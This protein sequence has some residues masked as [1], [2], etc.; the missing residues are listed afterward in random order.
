MSYFGVYKFLKQYAMKL[1][2]F[3]QRFKLLLILAIVL[4]I[5]QN[6]VSQTVIRYDLI[7]AWTST[8]TT[9]ASLN[10]GTFSTNA[11]SPA[12]DGST[13]AYATGWNSSG[14][15]W[16]SSVLSTV[17]Y[18]NVNISFYMK[19]DSNGPKSFDLQYKTSAG[20]SWIQV[21][22]FSSIL[23]TSG[24]VAKTATLPAGASNQ[25]T[26]YIQWIQSGAVATSSSGKNYIS[27]VNISAAALSYPVVQ[28]SAIKII[29]RTSKTITVSWTKGGV[30][31]QLLMINNTNDFT[32]LPVNNE[33][34]TAISGQYS[35]SGR[36]VIFNTTDVN[37]VSTFTVQVPSATDTYWF[38]V[39][40]YEYNAG[41]TRYGPSEY[42][43]AVD[44]APTNPVKCY[45]EQ[46]TLN[47]AYF[48]LVTADIG[49][50][51]APKRGTISERGILYSTKQNFIDTDPEAVQLMTDNLNSDGYFHLEDY[52]YDQTYTYLQRGKTI[53]YKAYVKNQYGTIYTDEKSFNNSPIFSGTGNWEDGTNWNVHEVP[54]STGTVDHASID[55]KTTINGT[56]TLTASNSVTNLTISSGSLA[57]N[58][59]KSMNVVGILIN[60][61]GISGLIIKSAQDSP[62]GTLTFASG[63]PQASVEMYSQATKLNGQNHWQYFG[64][65]VQSQTVGTTFN[66]G[67]GDERVRRYN[68]ANHDA[69]GHDYGLWYPYPSLTMGTDETLSPVTG[70]EVVQST[71]K[72]YTFQ[73]TLNHTDISQPLAYTNNA[74]YQGSNIL[75]NPFTASIDIRLLSFTGD[76][77]NAFYIYNT[78]SREEWIS[79]GGK[80]TP[81]SNAGTYSVSTG[82]FAGIFGVPAEIPSMQGFLV[83]AN[84]AGATLEIPY[85]SIITTGAS[86]P[87]RSQSSVSSE[88]PATRI[89]VLGTNYSDR[90]WIFTDPSFSRNFDNGFDGRKVLA[91]T[92]QLFSVEADANYQID[93]I[94]DLNQTYLGFQPGV[95]TDFTMNFTHQNLDSKYQGI[96]LLDLVANKTIDITASGSEY[97]FTSTPSTT[98]VKRFEIITTP[99]TITGSDI[100]NDNSKL[101]VFSSQRSVFIQ[102]FTGKVGNIVLYNLTGVAVRNVPFNSNGITTIS[103]LAAGVYIARASCDNEE[104]NVQLL[105]R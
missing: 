14:H 102:N 104:V 78:G 37:A 70:Y 89:D 33:I 54:G 12:L 25:P 57:I 79:Y 24:T 53:Y 63:T 17:G 76:V 44:Y 82:G 71:A 92:T 74:D 101:K 103:D 45:L 32:P 60:S 21:A 40:D 34:F 18:S 62:N 56:C 73:G 20:G 47:D 35:G 42:A 99:K 65:P 100:V 16:S 19:S 61:V 77:E 46:I 87:Q 15:S 75:A 51:I 59:A 31:P 8:P 1:K 86:K 95:D 38:R 52:L 39:F 98:A 6:V 7:S 29:A 83:N 84:S 55:D 91:S 30:Q 41:L 28:S 105:I 69:S 88:I 3:T 13:W 94:N 27:S 23:P 97:K 43:A 50:T 68:E 11:T 9:P 85:S 81:G 64:I 5:G 93:A 10:T 4:L 49:A 67:G 90:M 22:N 36:A 58:P 80:N 66:V 72:T 96:Y 2:M 48:K 26:L